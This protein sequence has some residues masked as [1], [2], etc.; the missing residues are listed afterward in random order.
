M[1]S[2]INEAWQ[3]IFKLSWPSWKTDFDRQVKKSYNDYKKQANKQQKTPESVEI[4]SN[5]KR[6]VDIYM[7]SQEKQNKTKQNQ[8]QK[9][10]QKQKQKKKRKRKK[11]NKR[12]YIGT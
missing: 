10:K 4:K 2:H 8:K 11:G 12:E 1:Q 7:I 9:K 3:T 6:T 5:K